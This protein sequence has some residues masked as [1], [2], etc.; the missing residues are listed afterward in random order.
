MRKRVGLPSKSSSNESPMD[1]D[2]M[3][4]AIKHVG[5]GSVNIVRNL[6][7]SVQSQSARRVPVGDHGMW[8]CEP[9]IGASEEPIRGMTGYCISRHALDISELLEHSLLNVR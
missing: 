7:R 2:L 5:L 1:I 8:L 6:L 9:V 3:H 4:G